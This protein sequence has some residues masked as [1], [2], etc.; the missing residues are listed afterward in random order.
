MIN[1][2]R[3]IPPFPVILKSFRVSTEAC[4]LLCEKAVDI[5]KD[6]RSCK[7]DK[8]TTSDLMESAPARLSV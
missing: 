8:P 1:T 7:Y 5:V 2:S 3:V 4:S 6:S